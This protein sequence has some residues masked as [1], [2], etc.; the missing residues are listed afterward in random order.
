MENSEFQRDHLLPSI[1]ITS[2]RPITIAE[3]ETG[4]LVQYDLCD[5]NKKLD[6]SY[7]SNFEYLGKGNIY[8][9]GGVLQPDSVDEL[10]FF[11]KK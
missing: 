3:L 9:V 11:K 1:G 6:K 5:T 10:F 7:A 4:E 8:S 2:P